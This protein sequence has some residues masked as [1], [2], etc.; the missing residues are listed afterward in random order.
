MEQNEGM[1][2]DNARNGREEER[3]GMSSKQRREEMSTE[4]GKYEQKRK[5]DKKNGDHKGR[6][7][8]EE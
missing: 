4:D 7:R 2:R 1:N 6:K 3:K 5:E 8:Y